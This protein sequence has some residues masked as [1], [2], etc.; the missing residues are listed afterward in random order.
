[1]ERETAPLEPGTVAEPVRVDPKRL[2]VG[3]RRAAVEAA[4]APSVVW[5]QGAD[6]LLVHVDGV[7][8]RTGDGV[9]M[10]FVDV[11]CDQLE[12]PAT[13]QVGFAVGTE[14]RPTGM[15]AAATRPDGP[16]LVVDRW[17]DALVAFAWQTLL[18]AAAGAAAEAGEDADGAALIPAALTA[19]REGLV[20]TP[21]ARHAKDRRVSPAVRR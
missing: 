12:G 17:T 14:K 18:D 4:G 7:K 20:V 16:P 10:V 9:V 8:V 15:L 3:A 11:A 6:A 13:I 21:Q 5:T 1:M 2:M 19:S